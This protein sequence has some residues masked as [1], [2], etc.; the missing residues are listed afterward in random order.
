[1]LE[2][3]FVFILVFLAFMN[4][5]AIFIYMRPLMEDLSHEDF[6]KVFFK[7]TVLSFLIYYFFAI[8]GNF[9]FEKIFR[10]DFEAFRVFGGI[11][12]FA[13]A[14]N[15]IING[16]RAIIQTKENL[17]NLPS[18]IA[19]P[20]L[21]GAGTISLSILIGNELKALGSLLVIALVMALTYGIVIFLKHAR[22]RFGKKLQVAFDKSM[23]I[24]LR[25]S[26]FFMGAIG[27]NMVM[28]G[29]TNFFF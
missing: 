24:L 18:E 15:F 13:L 9:I 17:D 11:I 25:L 23:V 7:A 8:T 6:I 26:G 28:T 12:V 14:F 19:L 5:F 4:P 29:I 20:F 10:I 16:R 3:A 1:M 2:S 22:E 21:V 27:V